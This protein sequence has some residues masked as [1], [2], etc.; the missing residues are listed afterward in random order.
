M[1]LH[2]L[3]VLCFDPEYSSYVSPSIIFVSKIQTIDKMVERFRKAIAE[4]LLNIC[5]RSFTVVETI[6]AF[7]VN[8]S[9]IGYSWSEAK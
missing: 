9:L 6:L 4:F 3:I 5:G 7:I 2:Y 8:D 1:I